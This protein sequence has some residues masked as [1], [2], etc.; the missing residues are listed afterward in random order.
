MN[1]RHID[2]LHVAESSFENWIM[3]E[4]TPRVRLHI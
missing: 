4:D 3:H 2:E 1:A